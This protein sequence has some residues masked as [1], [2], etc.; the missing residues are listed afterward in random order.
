M[1]VRKLGISIFVSPLMCLMLLGGIVLED[2]THVKP[3]DADPYHLRAREVIEN[4]PKQISQGSWL[5]VKDEPLPTPAEQLLHPN[6]AINRSYRSDAVWANGRPVEA[7]LL[8][9]QCRDSRDMAG[10]YPPN[11]YPAS[12]DEQLSAQ[13]FN[14]A[15]GG[16]TIDGMEYHFLQKTVPVSRRCVYD[17]FIVP[18]KGIVADM[19]GVRRAAGDYQRRFYGAAQFQV[20]MDA[21][22]P[23]DLREQV[24][25]MIIGANPD[26]FS[27]L[28][29]VE[30]P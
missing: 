17:F 26:A 10:H 6:A 24:F 13:K 30:M 3:S 1:A 20:I 5:T 25:K 9:V 23:Q 19:N 4:W 16:V 21:D 14:L 8:I 12:G 11:C 29:T 2:R 27:A 15:A 28:N 18:G 22:L 7:S